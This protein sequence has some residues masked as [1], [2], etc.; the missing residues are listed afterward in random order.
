MR[1]IVA[2]TGAQVV[3]NGSGSGFL[4]IGGAHGVAPFL[5]GPLGFQDHRENLARRHEVCQFTKK[6]TRFVNGVEAASF[7]LGE[8]HGLD[9]DD[10]EPGFVNARKDF[11]L[12]AAADG[13][14]FNNGKRAFKRHEKGPPRD[15]RN[16]PG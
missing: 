15:N 6:R 11:A 2:D 1:A 7:F 14:G 16:P 9:G 10:L 8:P 13:V 3:A 4:G 12:L 5:D